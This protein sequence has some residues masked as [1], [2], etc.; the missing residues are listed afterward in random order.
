MPNSVIK[1]GRVQRPRRVA[2]R[3]PIVLSSD[4]SAD[5]EHDA[6]KDWRPSDSSTGDD[7]E[8]EDNFSEE[9]SDESSEE[10]V[11]DDMDPSANDDS[12][13]T[14]RT[15]RSRAK[16]STLLDLTGREVVEIDDDDGDLADITQRLGHADLNNNEK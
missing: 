11:D 14:P 15:R 4:E 5:D 10:P 3:D 6:D 8:L 12:A 9:S 2:V 13:T 16:R 1:N 7:T